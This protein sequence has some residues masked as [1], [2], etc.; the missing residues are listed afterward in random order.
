M[1][2]LSEELT[3]VR[4]AAREFAERE[5]KPRATKHD[6]QEHLD[7]EVLK[8]IG[9]LGFWGLTVSEEYGG[10][11]LGNLALSIVLEEL[12]RGCGAT[13]VTVSVHNSLLC[14]PLMKYGNAEQ[15]KRFLPKLAS[16]EWIGAYCLTEP[17]SGSDAAALST[18]AVKDGDHYVLD[19]DRKSVV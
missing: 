12:N 5:L 4:D 10:S 3:M 18:R 13:G 15:K 8:L 19:G 14:S 16:G 6:R 2:E 11:G 7:A 1:F 17:G 9:E